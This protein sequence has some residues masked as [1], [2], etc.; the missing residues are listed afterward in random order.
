M[1]SLFEGCKKHKHC[2]DQAIKYEIFVQVEKRAEYSKGINKF[3]IYL[4]NISN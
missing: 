2:E 4:N 3:W 1:S